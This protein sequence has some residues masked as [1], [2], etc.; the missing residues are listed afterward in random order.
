MKRQYSR[1]ELV[2]YGKL[3]ELTMGSGGTKPD[4]SPPFVVVNDNC[5]ASDPAFACLVT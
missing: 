1:P 2:T 5:D 4:L 3:S